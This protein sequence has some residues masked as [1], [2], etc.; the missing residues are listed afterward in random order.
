MGKVLLVWRLGVK[1]IRR[2]ATQAI[3]LLL[4]I[5]AGATTLTLGLALGGTTNNPYAR[6]RAATNGPD[7]VATVSPGG[8][9]SAGPANP[10][11]L[12]ALEQAPAVVAHSGPFPVTWALLRMGHTTAGTEVEGR[13]STPSPVDQPK[14]LQGTSVRPGGV[15]IEAGFAN[16][17]GLH[18]GDR[19][20]LGGSSF[21]VLGIAV[22]AAI[23]T[24]TQVCQLGCFL[25]GSISS[26]NPGLIWVPEAD[27]AHLAAADSEPVAYYLN[28][29][30]AD[31]AAAPAFVERYGTHASPG[32]PSL[33]SWQRIRDAD[34]QVITNVQAVL[35][36]G[37]WLLALLA[38]ASVAVLVGG[39]MAEQTRR[40]GLLKAVGGTP[41]LVA[42]V[43]LFEHVL[44]GICAA[45]VGLLA[46]WL[47]APSM[48][49]V[50]AGLL[51]APNA[52]SV[53]GSS[54][55][56]VV[57]LALGVAIAATFVP[58][59]RAARQSTVAA[60]EDSARVPRRRASVIRLSTHL[61]APLLLGTRLVFRRPRRLVLSVFSVAVTASGLMAVLVMHATAAGWSFGPRLAQ[62]TTI[63]SVMLVI[64]AAI[65][66]I[67][68]AWTT[69][70]E[71]RHPAALARALGATPEQITTGLSVAQL[72]PALVGALLGIPG[73]IGIFDAAK[74]SGPTT[75]P[76]ALWIVVMVIGT[77]LSIAVLTAIPTRIGASRPVTEVLQAEAA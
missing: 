41:Q 45:G 22:T 50:G 60:L 56:L 25:S 32:A 76:P 57:A 54:V 31:P 16:A 28:I 75:V 10:D 24:Y 27:V 70:L 15:V 61:P 29:K 1:D 38:L 52:P 37:G 68:I 11:G 47:V 17:L 30:L 39:R 77:L 65:N 23:P 62:A 63:T 36:T 20:N 46:G 42:V 34:A 13:S 8:P 18:V 73:G 44:V 9:F 7:V 72:L 51:G 2:R 58:A 48:S 33:F 64:L 69:A 66:A 26:Y 14:L 21:E 53:S 12:V 71:A 35:L 3:L 43:L 55:G 4:A 49:G 5:A 59:I 19:L 74:A 40:V 6:T 67:F